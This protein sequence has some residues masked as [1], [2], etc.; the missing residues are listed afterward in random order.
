MNSHEPCGQCQLIERPYAQLLAPYLYE[1]PVDQM[2]TG[3]KFQRRRVFARA[4]AEALDVRCAEALRGVDLLVPVP[5]HWS[6]QWRRGF[7]Q[8]E[9]ILQF[10]GKDELPPVLPRALVRCRRTQ[11]QSNLDQEARQENVAG[12][13]LAHRKTVEGKSIGLLD[14]VVTTGATVSQ[15]A[16]A[17]LSAGARSVSVFAFAR[18]A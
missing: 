1:F 3:L 5:L 10:I 18:A 8:C 4:I 12:A 14:D 6:R 13:F 16:E 7:N 9:L 2:I 17:L 15:A 11:A